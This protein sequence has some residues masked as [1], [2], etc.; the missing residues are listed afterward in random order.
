MT[1]LTSRLRGLAATLALVAF[2]AAVPV[3]LVAIGAVPDLAA[4]SWSRL[5]AP[6]DGTLV[7]EILSVVCWT[8]W[9]IFTCQ[10]TF[11]IVARIRGMRAPRLP[12]LVL[13]QLAADRLVAAAAL[14]FVAVPS[15]AAILPQPKAQGAVTSTP[16][17]DPPRVA[18]EPTAA[19]PQVD[20]VEEKREPRVERYTVVRGDSLWR[21]AEDRLGDGAR[22]VELVDLNGAVLDGRPDFLLPGTVL[23]VPTVD[24]GRSDEYVVQ[25]GDTLSEIAE[26]ELG[27]AHAYPSIFKASNDSVQ[28]DG[29][30]LTDP[31]LI[32]PGWQ[33]TIPGQKPTNEPPFPRHAKPPHQEASPPSPPSEVAPVEPGDEPVTEPDDDP[34]AEDAGAAVPPWLVPGLAGAGSILGAALWLALRAQRRTQLRYRRPGTIVPPPP[35]ELDPI[36]KTARATASTIAPGIDVLDAALRS[37]PAR[38]RLV[39]VTL[40]AAEIVLTLHE[41][42]DLPHPW[43]GARTEWRISL[44]DVPERPEDSFPPFP[45]LASVGR[46]SDGSF[47]FLNLEELRI[48]TVSGNTG[49]KAAFA[50]HLAAELAVN[51]WSIVTTVDLLGLGSDLASFNVGRVR[52]HPAGDTDFIAQRARN[53]GSSSEPLDPDDFHAVIIATADRPAAELERLAEVIQEIPGRSSA[54]LIDLAGKPRSSHVDLHLTADGRLQLPSLGVDVTAAGLSEDEARA[55]ALLLDLTLDDTVVPVPQ[56]VDGTAVSDLGGALVEGLTEPRDDGPAGEGS[57]LPHDALVY[58]DN[59]ATTVADVGVLAP[60]AAPGARATVEAADPTLDEDLARWESPTLSS[61]KLALLGQV[62]ARTMGDTKATAHRRP[63]YVELLAYLALHPNGVSGQDVADAFGLRPERVRVDMSQLRRWLGTNPGTG[64]PFLPKAEPGRDPGSPALYKLDGVLS[65]LDLFRRLRTRGQSRGADGIEDLIAALRLVSG[66]PFTEL[67]EGHWNWLLDCDR[68]DHI[69]TSAIVDVGHIVTAHALA[70]DDH[71]LAL[72]AAQVAYTAAPYDEVAQLDMVQAERS[73]GHHQK[74]NRAL[75]DKV[76][77]R[78]DDEL[79]PI[80]LPQRTAQ[81]VDDKDWRT[82][83]PRPRRTG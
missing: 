50:R 40:A 35:P 48:V 76:F 39:M 19:A 28:A 6:D 15:A 10:L 56:P 45:L 51:P 21:I 9:A 62:G 26:E 72:W 16:L 8:A 73:A 17:P 77:D 29:R 18:V 65:D 36:E 4:F 68:W 25:P 67:R 23:R 60:R 31:D 7:L 61:A 71:E 75:S 38:L 54:A 27:D 74:A 52:A 63:F 66:E 22:Y 43:R 24:E 13:P 69:M 82:R 20:A 30:R 5:T 46:T 1:T 2:V 42:A 78:R 11:S 12:G 81:I 79:A 49:R 80:D 41:A 55:C 83:G 59:A 3:V 44:A 14:L 58:A 64:E 37:L 70:A 47:L 33:L 53:L 34:T 32:L 57:L